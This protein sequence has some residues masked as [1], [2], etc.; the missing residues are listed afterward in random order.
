VLSRAVAILRAVAGEPQGLS[1]SELADRT[2]LPRSTVHRL[3]TAL[4]AERLLAAASPSGRV[5]IGADVVRLGDDGRPDV[6]DQ[7]RPVL[8]RLFDTLEETVD[9]AR[10]DGDHLR[11]L[12]QIPAPHRLRAVSAAGSTFP[13]HCTANGK[14]VLSLL[15]DEEVRA[16]LP[17][18][19][20]RYTANTIV[21]RAVLLRELA[22]I[23]RS[24]V[25]LDYEEHTLGIC[26]A[27][28]AI[29]EPLGALVAVSVPVPTPRF[30]AQAR[31]VMAA[32]RAARTDAMAALAAAAA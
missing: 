24:G 4:Q 27:S 20:S 32:L 26:A 17:A 23:R 13:L 9:L 28:F 10:L 7:L 14:A 19:L 18:E 2:S 8:R 5:R 3:V 11:F 31:E 15:S 16:L 1:L 29:R 12:E 25:A 6:S 30:Q 21:S 22:E